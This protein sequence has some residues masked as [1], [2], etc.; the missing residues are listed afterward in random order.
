VKAP[1]ISA[2]RHKSDITIPVFGRIGT[3]SSSF[4]FFG[5]VSMAAFLADMQAAA[6][7]CRKTSELS[8]PNPASLSFITD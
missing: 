6:E 2:E 8:V 1:L 3:C 5:I 4:E 7:E